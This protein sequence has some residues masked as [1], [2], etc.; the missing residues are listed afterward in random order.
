MIAIGVQLSA[1]SHQA[2]QRTGDANQK[3]SQSVAESAPI[4]A[5]DHQVHVI[6]LHRKKYTLSHRRRLV[7]QRRETFLASKPMPPVVPR[8]FSLETSTDS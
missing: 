4:V 3:R 6:P 5:L 8:H 2:V 1:R 7:L